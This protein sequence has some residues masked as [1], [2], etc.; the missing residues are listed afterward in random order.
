LIAQPRVYGGIK[1]AAPWCCTPNTSGVPTPPHGVTVQG[2]YVLAHRL[3]TSLPPRRLA[4]DG[5]N[6][7]SDEESEEETDDE[8]A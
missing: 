7:D 4:D 5:E 8:E 6:K 2:L 3:N 1:V